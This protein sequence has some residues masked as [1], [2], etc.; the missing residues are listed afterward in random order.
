MTDT[1]MNFGLLERSHLF[2][3]R[4]MDTQSL[5]DLINLA[6][7]ILDCSLLICD[8]QGYILA[9]SPVEERACQVFR[10]TV[11]NT[12]QIAKEKLKTLLGPTPLCNV[13]RDS[14]CVGDTCTRFSFPLKIGEQGLP[15]AI[16]FFIWDRT[17]SQDDQ[18]LISMIA[19]A[20]SVFMRKNSLLNNTIQASRISLLRELLDY[21]PGLKSYYERSLAMEHLHTLGN[22]FHLACVGASVNAPT[23]LNPDSLALEI[24]YCLPSAWVFPYAENVLVVFHDTN[25]ESQEVITK[26]DDLLTAHQLHACLS[27]KF[28]NLIDLRYMYEDTKVCLSI[29]R[30]K[31]SE[32][33]VFLAED[34]LDLAFLHKC[35]EF[36]PLE[37]YY[38]EGF[39]RLRKFEAENEKGYLATLTAYLDNNMSVNAASKAIFMHRNT[40]TQQLEKIEEILGVSLKDSR[41]CWYLRLCLKI[42]ELL[43]L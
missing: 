30:K 28:S 7:S 14:L 22:G 33:C 18:A 41:M 6:C 43:H 32:R 26:L 8:G 35:R 2:M 15:G 19:G 1:T 11:E 9:H 10:N 31:T 5:D 29:A 3:E 21:K 16:T 23:K 34:Y 17:L 40:M 13:M 20:F 12:R 24:Q 36:F 39:D 27:C 4:L 38:T 37:Q 25:V 42:H